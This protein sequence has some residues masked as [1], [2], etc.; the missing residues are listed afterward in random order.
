MKVKVYLQRQ[1]E[2]VICKL[3]PDDRW[4]WTSCYK[5]IVQLIGRE[6]RKGEAIELDLEATNVKRRSSK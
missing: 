1:D 2:L 6:L 3:A 5:G 4:F